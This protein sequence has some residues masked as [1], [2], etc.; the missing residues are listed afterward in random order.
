MC[1]SFFL[2]LV[3]ILGNKRIYFH[4]KEIACFFNVVLH[5]EMKGKAMKRMILLTISI[6]FLF[7]SCVLVP[8][9]QI[10]KRT[11]PGQVKKITGRNPASGKWK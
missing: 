11:A 1:P 6:L 8:P 3:E 2:F 10:K 4:G 7:S 5:T 9:G